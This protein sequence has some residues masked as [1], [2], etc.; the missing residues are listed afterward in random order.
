M[1]VVQST[2]LRVA[3]E[4]NSVLRKAFFGR[5]FL[6]AELRG[7]SKTLPQ[8]AADGAPAP[9]VPTILL[10]DDDPL[11][12]ATLGQGLR[13]AG[14]EVLGA[15][16]A[17]SAIEICTSREIAVAVVDYALPG[18][19]GVELARM[20]ADRTPVPVVFL[21]AYD[22]ESIVRDAIAA[23]AMSYL[24]KPID[25]H[26]LLP[27]IRTALQRSRE[28]KALRLQTDQLNSAL[29]S[30]RSVNIATGLLMARFQIG[31]E[32]AFERLRR[33]A[34]STRARLEEV[35]TELI[36]VSDEVDR[37]YEPLRHG[38]ALRRPESMGTET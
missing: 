35:A 6:M 3:C 4:R 8:R 17:A 1:A 32:E 25:T 21:S 2:R 34:R 36:R 31:Q 9:P 23:G 13:H 30:S 7:A 12:V 14:F 38:P 22:D 19:S 33:H 28:L 16:D 24:V 5:T 37:L 26:Q 27:V 10:A 11:I 15:F 20:I 29:Q 18:T